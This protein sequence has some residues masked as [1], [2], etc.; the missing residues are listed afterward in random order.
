VGRS[1][2]QPQP[3]RDTKKLIKFLKE[4]DSKL[5]GGP[6]VSFTVVARENKPPMT[7]RGYNEPPEVFG[8]FLLPKSNVEDY[9]S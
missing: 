1:A 5:H 9:S 6:G 7:M 4:L 8:Y 2:P 3:P